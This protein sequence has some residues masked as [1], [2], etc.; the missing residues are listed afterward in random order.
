MIFSSFYSFIHSF[1]FLLLFF[2]VYSIKLYQKNNTMVDIK[3]ETHFNELSSFLANSMFESK[4][5]DLQYPTK[6]LIETSENNLWGKIYLFI[7]QTYF[8]QEDNIYKNLLSIFDWWRRNKKFRSTIDSNLKE[9]H[10]KTTNVKNSYKEMIEKIELERW[11]IYRETFKIGN[12]RPKFGAKFSPVLEQ[13]LRA[14]VHCRSFL[15]NYNWLRSKTWSGKY[16]CVNCN[17]EFNLRLD[18]TNLVDK[19][20][21]LE[22]KAGISKCNKMDK[23]N[24][25]SEKKNIHTNVQLFCKNKNKYIDVHSLITMVQT[26]STQLLSQSLINDEKSKIKGFVHETSIFPYGFLLQSDIQVNFNIIN[27]N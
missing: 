4:T 7:K 15:E 13:I 21:M 14:K 17:C 26:E 1:I 22:I 3:N 19:F 27:F 12:K 23:L 16:H 18:E 25:E 8:I 11:L 5:K 10:K 2:L 9:L 24:K 20:V 6:K